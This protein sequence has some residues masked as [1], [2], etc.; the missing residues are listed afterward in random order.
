MKQI[1]VI[2]NM[3]YSSVIPTNKALIISF[4]KDAIIKAFFNAKNYDFIIPY[5]QYLF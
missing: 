2:N 1:E 5:S 4:H 3:G